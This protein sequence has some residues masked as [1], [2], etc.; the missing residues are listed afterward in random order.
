MHIMYLTSS[1]CWDKHRLVSVAFTEVDPVLLAYCS[2][3]HAS[4]TKDGLT[5]ERSQ[6]LSLNSMFT[7]ILDCQCTVDRKTFA[8]I[9]TGHE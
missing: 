1:S 9:E 2:I 8:L 7:K 3:C 5:K 6:N 4:N